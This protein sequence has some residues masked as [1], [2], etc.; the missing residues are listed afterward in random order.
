[1]NEFQVFFSIGIVLLTIL[2]SFIY[3]IQNVSL[4]S[5]FIVMYLLGALGWTG[6]YF[7]RLFP[8]SLFQVFS[9]AALG[10]DF[11][12][13][14]G[15]LEFAY[16]PL[17][18]IW[19][20]IFAAIFEETIRYICVSKHTPVRSDRIRGPFFVGLGWATGEIIMV[21]ALPLIGTIAS[22]TAIGLEN[23]IPGILERIIASVLHI[24]LTFIVLYAIWESRPKVSLLVAMLWHFLFNIFVVVFMAIFK[25]DIFS[26]LVIIWT[27]E[28]VLCLTSIA[29][30][31]FVWKYWIPK[32]EREHDLPVL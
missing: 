25:E 22:T 21:Y 6:A 24:G 31:I 15:I 10:A 4:K 26:N 13:Q 29:L 9:L 12:S 16:H 19:G 27:L 30:I 28:I 23:Y 32:K 3:M 8:L 1:M 18:N 2:I 7:L 17:V 5:K 11:T 20:P 14:E